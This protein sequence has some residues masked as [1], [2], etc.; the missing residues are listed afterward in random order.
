VSEKPNAI[1]LKDY[2]APLFLIETIEMEVDIYDDFTFVKTKLKVKK[3][4][5][6][7][8]PQ[9]LVLNG[10]KLEFIALKI[11]NEMANPERF[12]LSEQQLVIHDFKEEEAV[13]I[14][15][16]IF[17]Q[18]NKSLEGFYQSGNIFCT[19]CESEGFRK[20]TYFIDRPDNMS[21]FLVTLKADKK[22]FPY[23]LANGNRVDQGDLEANRHFVKW[24]DPFK[25]PSYLFAMVAGDLQRV[26]DEFKTQSGRKV[27]IEFYVDPGQGYKCQHAIE[28]LKASM[29]WDEKTYGLEYDLDLYMVVAVE[30]F[31]F[32]AMENKGLN[33]FNSAYVLADSKTATD[34]DFQHIEGVIGHEYFHNWSGN[35]VTCRDW[36]Q[37]TLKEGL[38]VYRDQEFSSDQLSRSVKRIE[39]VRRLKEIQ[40]PEDMGPMSHP[41]RPSFYIEINNFYTAT[42]YEKGAEIIRMIETIIGKDQFKKGLALYFKRFDGQAVT[43]DDFVLAMAEASGKDFSQFKNWYSRPGTP[44]LKF[45]VVYDPHLKNA[46]IKIEQIYPKVG[47]EKGDLG[48][49]EMPLKMS[50]L[51]SYGKTIQVEQTILLHQMNQ[52]INIPNIHSKPILSL[53][54]QFSAPVEIDYPISKEELITLMGHDSDPYVK[55]ESINQLF[56]Q[57]I[58]NLFKKLQL[59]SQVTYDLP[60][61]LKDAFLKILDDKQIESSLKSLYLQV[62]SENQLLQKLFPLDFERISKARTLFLKAIGHS[63][64]DFWLHD[65]NAFKSKGTFGV[66]AQE[67]GARAWRNTCLHYLFHGDKN[68]TEPILKDFFNSAETMTEEAM[69]LNLYCQS[70]YQVKDEMITKFYKKWKHEPLVMLRWFGSQA[71]NFKPEEFKAGMSRLETDPVFR[72]EVPNDLRGLYG[73]FARQNLVSFHHQSGQGYQFMIE[74]VKMIDRFNPQVASRLLG[75]FSLIVKLDDVRKTQM[76]QA[77]KDLLADTPSNDVYEVASR[78]VNQQ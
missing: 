42:V 39:D 29:K 9:N 74:K 52:T 73:S 43:T 22:R 10:E 77:L 24:H 71:S 16:K 67:M 15:N 51:D 31:N 78:L 40:F 49:L 76:K 65:L 17:P 36:F 41:I 38:T 28:S 56:I 4:H 72:K 58:E 62:P 1:Y 35:R 13:E 70:D 48:V 19:Q 45:E 21:S 66:S 46:Q 30:S 37:L 57:E 26:V 61:N 7:S 54:R 34:D 11:N 50:V 55:S 5:S 12:S 64:Y 68:K 60:K 59:D 53:N 27:G 69:A 23:L 20:I 14:H 32:G 47:N 33:I 25:K 3:N 44:R 2:K 75:Q 6:L 63:F 8:S 18:R